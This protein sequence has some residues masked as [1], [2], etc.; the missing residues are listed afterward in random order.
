MVF[1]FVVAFAVLVGIVLGGN[2]ARLGDLRLRAPWI[3]FVAIALQV[4]AFPSGLLPWGMD[5]TVA[6]VLWLVSF[7]LLAWGAVLNRHI[8]GAPI[9]ALGMLLN[10]VA[11][12]AN[13]GHMPVLRSALADAGLSYR[14]HNNSL[15][16]AHPHLPWLVDRWA[17]PDWIPL[18]NVYSIGDVAISVGTIILVVSAMGA[19]R[20]RGLAWLV[21]GRRLA[22][23]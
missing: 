5:D 3:F 1:L 4:A 10:L 15:S 14:L 22:S 16:A 11:I 8:T 9:I 7:G 2:P 12:S 23:G 18:A 19:L 21:R 17:A 6:R 13:G 20:G